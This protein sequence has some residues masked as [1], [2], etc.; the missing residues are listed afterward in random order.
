MCFY[1]SN[2]ILYNV[3]E[4]S[5]SSKQLTLKTLNHRVI[6][7]DQI[8]IQ[9][10]RAADVLQVLGGALS[11]LFVVK[12]KMIKS[13]QHLSQIFAAFNSFQLVVLL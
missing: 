2:A 3:R 13:C 11:T 12:I 8:I 9:T 1:N 6:K 4:F 5:T 10:Q 7:T